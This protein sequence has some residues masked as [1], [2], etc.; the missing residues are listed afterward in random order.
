[1]CVYVMRVFLW[2][3]TWVSVT[4]T[5]EGDCSKFF[6][7]PYFTPSLSPQSRECEGGAGGRGKEDE[8]GRGG[9]E[10]GGG[11]G[12]L[13]RPPLYEFFSGKR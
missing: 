9:G 12:G 8:G 11:G 5:V 2:L 3:R 10:G 6:E 1:M 4:V 13:S 7:Q